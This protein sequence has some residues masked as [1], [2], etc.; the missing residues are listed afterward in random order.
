MSVSVGGFQVDTS[1]F[2]FTNH[3]SRVWAVRTTNLV[4]IVLVSAF[5]ALRLFVRVCIVGKVFTDDATGRGLGTHV[6]LLPITKIFETVKDCIQVSII[7]SYLRFIQDQRFRMCMYVTAVIIAGLWFTGVFVA[8]FQC[9]PVQ[10]AWD[11]TI[12]NRKCIN[13][14]GYL[15]ASSAVTVATDLVLCFLPLPYLW[16]LQMPLKQ[17]VIL[18]MLFAGGAGACIASIWRIAKLETLRSMDLTFQ[19]VPCLNLSVIECSIGIVCVSIP[20]LRPLAVRLWPKDFRNS[21]EGS[22][23]TPRTFS[24]AK[25]SERSEYEL[26]SCFEDDTCDAN[27]QGKTEIHNESM[28]TNDQG[29]GPTNVEECSP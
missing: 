13:F 11:F 16:R 1:S 17:R 9:T 29:R 26:E 6:Y 10:A 5:V 14:I 4:L 27:N 28:T 25:R 18:C 8:I 2:D 21:G 19:C 12:P 20:S 3:T 22:R 24:Y 15:Y 7:A 23:N